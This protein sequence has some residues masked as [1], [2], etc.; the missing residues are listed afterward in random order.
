MSPIPS[1]MRNSAT[2]ERLTPRFGLVG[3]LALHAAIVAAMLITWTHRLEIIDQSSAIVPVDLVTLG[4]K[5]NVAPMVKPELPPLNEQPTPP[6]MPAMLQPPKIEVAPDAKP[7]PKTPPP[8]PEKFD[9]NNIQA[10]L[11]KRMAAS[12]NAKTGPRNVTGIGAQSAMTADLATLLFNEIRQ[13]W[14][15]PVGAPNAED[16]I[17]AYDVYLNRDGS[18]AQTPQLTAD[19]AAAAGGNSYKRAAADAARRA[20]YACAPYQLPA[21]RYNQWHAFTFIFDPRDMTE[22]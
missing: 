13:C 1:P 22:Q 21:D 16:L 2:A 7:A 17:V 8:K 20:I 9:I 10:M 5:T 15:P 11:D 6:P 19:S 14:S 4:E 3:S 18:V 12:P